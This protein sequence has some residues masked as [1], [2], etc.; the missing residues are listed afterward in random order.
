[1]VEGPRLSS[2]FESFVG[3]HDVAIRHGLTLGE[4]A[5]L[6]QAERKLN[7]TEI[8]VVPC[9]GWRRDMFFEETALPWVLPSPNMPNIDTAVVYPG[10]C[11]LEGTNVSEGR[12]TTRPFELFGA[13][14]L[15]A[16]TLAAQL[17]QENLPGV[18]FRATWF[19]PTF[20][21]HADQQC[22]GVQLHVLE[23]RLFQPVRTSLAVLAA[24]RT[25]SGENFCWRTEPYEFVSHPIAI[26]LLFGSSRERCALESGQ[27]WREIAAAWKT[28]EQAFME[29]REPFLLYP[30]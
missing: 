12:G 23:R 28:E 9:Q 17:N 20:Q 1:M 22:S 27:P 24:L 13:P 14:W 8:E 2:G 19:Q 7:N 15:D 16:G 26:D 18:A 29:R 30:V 3:S 4:L 5:R 25:L 21:K 6:Y 10:Q 11:L